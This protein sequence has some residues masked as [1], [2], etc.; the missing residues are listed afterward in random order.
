MAIYENRK[1]IIGNGDD[2]IKLPRDKFSKAIVIDGY[3]LYEEKPAHEVRRKNFVVLD[4]GYLL[5]R[6]I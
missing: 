3:E 6:K 2:F 4:G 1:F 5:Y